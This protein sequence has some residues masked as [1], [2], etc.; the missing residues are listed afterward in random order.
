MKIR[1][2]EVTTLRDELEL[3]RKK[4]HEVEEERAANARQRD[5]EVCNIS[6]L[7]FQLNAWL[8]CSTFFF[9]ALMHC[10]SKMLFVMRFCCF[11]LYL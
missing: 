8:C 10:I 1:E 5:K 2:A 7:N 11:Y 6:K 3:V 4:K 9:R